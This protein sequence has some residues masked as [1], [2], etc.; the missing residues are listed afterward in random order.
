MSIEELFALLRE[1]IESVPFPEVSPEETA[2]LRE[3]G[4]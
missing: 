3:A 2:A 4:Q 1:D